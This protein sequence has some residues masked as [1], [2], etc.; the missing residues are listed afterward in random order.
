MYKH[1]LVPTDGSEL[2]N[3]AVS[4]GAELAKALG[5]KLT[6]MTTG[7]PTNVMNEYFAGVSDA[8]ELPERIKALEQQAVRHTASVLERAAAI[9]KQSGIFAATAQVER[10]HP[11]E[12]IIEVAQQSGCD[13]IVM[14]SH[15]RRGASALLLGSE[16]TKVLTHSKIPVL[17]HR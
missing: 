12:G 1:V 6:V 13:L 14:A 4:H 2:A 5:A 10:N 9:A 17:V 8:A 3:S 16:T 7:Q 15:G 11:Y